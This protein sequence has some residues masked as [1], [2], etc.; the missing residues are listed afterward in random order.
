MAKK[1]SGIGIGGV[2]FVLLIFGAVVWVLSENYVNPYTPPQQI[3]SQF[4]DGL[5]DKFIAALISILGFTLTVLLIAF[6]A[7][8][9]YLHSKSKRR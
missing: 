4:F 8:A 6:I 1:K 2:I 3:L 7:V 9:F 5:W